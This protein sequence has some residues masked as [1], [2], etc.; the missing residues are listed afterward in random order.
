MQI[1]RRYN[2]TAIAA[3]LLFSPIAASAQTCTTPGPLVSDLSS[4]SQGTTI[5]L[6]GIK[7]LNC[8]EIAMTEAWSGGQLIFSDSPESPATPGILY[9]DALLAATPDGIANRVFLYHVNGNPGNRMKFTVQITNFGTDAGTLTIKQQGIAGP[10]TNYLY[11]GKV[12]FERWL[13]STPGV[14]VSVDPGQTVKLDSG[15]DSTTAAKDFLLHGIWDYAFTQPHQVTICA[16]NEDDDPLTVCPSL[17]VLSR[18]SHQR[19]TF[20]H[21]DKIYK[22][23]DGIVVDTGSGVQQFS[24]AGNAPHDTNAQGIDRTDG[25]SMS[26]GGNYGI[27]YSIHI[28]TQSSDGQNLG[29]LVNPRAGAWGGAVKASPGLLPGGV[30]LIPVGT[31]AVVNNTEA[32]LAGEYSPGG[33]LTVCLQWMPTGGSSFPLR[34][35]AVP[36]S[37]AGRHKNSSPQCPIESSR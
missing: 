15:F 13:N 37:R 9:R 5:S 29:M 28:A 35:L 1:F 11:A 32:V 27:L 7:P 20:Q 30:F 6:S 4:A 33:V 10:T 12:A 14:P 17:P 23:A 25:S 24:L 18:D 3:L 19:G 2:V 16:L 31:G 26:L 36:Y 34:L 21:A 8:P 22:S